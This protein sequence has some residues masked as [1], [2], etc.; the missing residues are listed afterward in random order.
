MYV[1]ALLKVICGQHDFNDSFLNNSSFI[2]L[3]K[4]N[5]FFERLNISMIGS[6]ELVEILINLLVQYF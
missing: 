1:L 4:L 5:D 3:L 2:M 6:T